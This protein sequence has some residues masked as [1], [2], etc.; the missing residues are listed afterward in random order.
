MQYDPDIR[1]YQLEEQDQETTEKTELM[2]TVD[3]EYIL[4]HTFRDVEEHRQ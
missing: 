4:L 2:K 1:E 3:N